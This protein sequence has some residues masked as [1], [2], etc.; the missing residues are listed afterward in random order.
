MTKCSVENTVIKQIDHEI[1]L[2]NLI[3]ETSVFIVASPVSQ[4]IDIVILGARKSQ[5]NQRRIVYPDAITQRIFDVN[6]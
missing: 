4:K 1:N 6:G 2:K 5:S 3:L